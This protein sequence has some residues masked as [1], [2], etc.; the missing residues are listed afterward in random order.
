MGNSMPC[1][2]PMPTTLYQDETINP[3]QKVAAISLASQVVSI[4]H[5]LLAGLVVETISSSPRSVRSSTGCSTW[6][7]QLSQRPLTCRRWSESD[8]RA[9]PTIRP[10]SASRI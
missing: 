9:K 5:G 7:W 10:A 3:V 2:D 8:R 6:R 1:P 4:G